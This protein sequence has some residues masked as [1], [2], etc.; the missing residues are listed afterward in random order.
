MAHLGHDRSDATRAQPRGAASHQF[1]ECA[2]E[3]AF[4]E[5][6]LERKE[7]REDSD[8]HQQFLCRVAFHEGQER[9]VQRIRNF[10]LV[11]V[12][13]QEEHTLIDQLAD[14]ETKDLAEITTGD[15]FLRD[16]RQRMRMSC[17]RRCDVGVPQTPVHRAC[18]TFR[19]LSDRTLSSEDVRVQKNQTRP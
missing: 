15:Q 6:R 1:G 14:N 10:D 2:E 12:L 4:G 11:R 17:G 13:T 18:L 5:R 3:L 16:I 9:R 8:D 7:V 19:L